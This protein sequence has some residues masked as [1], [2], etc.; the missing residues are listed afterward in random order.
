[1]QRVLTALLLVVL[2]VVL[3]W[4]W[5]RAALATPIDVKLTSVSC[6]SNP[7]VTVIQNTG[8]L[9][10]SLS[11]FAINDIASTSGAVTLPGV[12]IPPAVLTAN[13]FFP[14]PPAMTIQPG[15]QFTFYSGPAALPEA[16]NQTTLT[17]QY[18]YRH[19]LA[20]TGREGAVLA[21][22]GQPVSFKFCNET[23]PSPTPTPSPTPFIPP[24]PVQTVTQPLIQPT[25]FSAV[26]PSVVTPVAQ[27]TISVAPSFSVPATIVSTP[28]PSF[29]PTVQQPVV[30]QPSEDVAYAPGW[31]LVAASDAML[32]SDAT[33]L[34]ALAN[35]G[36][37]Y[38]SVGA[39]DAAA[40]G[41]AYWAYFAPNDPSTGVAFRPSPSR[42]LSVP[43]QPGVWSMVGNPT[44]Y[45]LQVVGADVVYTF[46]SSDGYDASNSIEPGYGALVFSYSA[47][48]VTL[49]AEGS[50]G[51]QP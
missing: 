39:G 42:T 12:A 38:D 51:L 6:S 19:D 23:L 37:T 18:I 47:D 4:H 46:R 20:R 22:N 25:P 28:A 21:Y 7:E 9:A 43:I 5:Q 15:E 48:H 16:L 10:V 26:S 41:Q 33:S 3:L 1:M 49:S 2:G 13:P 29:T 8:L 27:P 35:D 32:Q 30:Q 50:L 44:Q 14:L 34:L 24:T 40:P 11:G 31:N 17:D 36:S 45:P